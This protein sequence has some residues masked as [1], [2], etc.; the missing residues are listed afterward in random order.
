[1]TDQQPGAQ[2]L[3]A[4]TE[5]LVAGCQEKR[6]DN[7]HEPYCFELFRRAIADK[8]Q[9]CWAAIYRQYQKLIGRWLLEILQDQASVQQEMLEP[10]V[11]EVYVAFWHAYTVEKLA[12]AQG[13][14]SVLSYLKAC[15]GT[16][17]LQVRRKAKKSV[18][19]TEWDQSAV[20]NDSAHT[21]ASNRPEQALNRKLFAER[22]WQLVDSICL[23][24]QERI[25]ARLSFV[26]NLKPNAILERHPESF[27]SVEEIY[28]M[29]R[30][31]KNRLARN[32]DLRALWGEVE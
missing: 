24:E 9:A 19:E 13:L 21:S 31:L 25:V 22:L 16:T 27:R 10:L 23:D 6:P 4:T 26:S 30:N 7:S 5:Q 15:A 20:D 2:P 3:P 17:A 11:S 1:M 32:P 18:L 8:D 12:Q 28:T 14:Q 29:R